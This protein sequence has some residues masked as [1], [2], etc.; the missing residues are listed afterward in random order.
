M[1]GPGHKDGELIWPWIR[2]QGR[3]R[4]DFKFFPESTPL[5]FPS[6]V[7]YTTVLVGA[8][9][10]SVHH[11]SAHR[12]IRPRE[13]MTMATNVENTVVETAPAG[14]RVFVGN[15]NYQTKENELAEFVT[16]NFANP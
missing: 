7:P 6:H 3:L 12:S 15:M 10:L 2:D 14:S 5:A 8:V 16:K 1:A 4:R 11:R 13:D 9:S